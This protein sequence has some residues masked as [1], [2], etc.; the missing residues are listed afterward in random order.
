MGSTLRRWYCLA[1]WLWH[2]TYLQQNYFLE[3]QFSYIVRIL[4]WRAQKMRSSTSLKRLTIGQNCS[5]VCI[6]EGGHRDALSSKRHEA[7]YFKKPA[8]QA[9][10]WWL[11]V[12]AAP[13]RKL[14]CIVLWIHCSSK[15]WTLDTNWSFVRSRPSLNWNKKPCLSPLIAKYGKSLPVGI[16]VCW[17][18]LG[19]HPHPY[20]MGS[21]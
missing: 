13:M 19:R 5:A 15:L 18:F 9:T 20:R 16:N 8:Q 1:P 6:N 3:R 11:A 7:L 4:T 10:P 21:S 17:F 12:V 2:Q 14:T